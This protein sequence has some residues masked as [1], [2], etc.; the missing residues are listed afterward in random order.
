MELC[1]AQ[2]STAVRL[3]REVKKQQRPLFEV[4]QQTKGIFSSNY[5]VLLHMLGKV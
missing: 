3:S 1:Q 2:F 4:R 5:G